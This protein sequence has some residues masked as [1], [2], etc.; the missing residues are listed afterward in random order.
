[1]QSSNNSGATVLF[2]G[3]FDPLH[4]GHRDAFAQAKALGSELIVVVAR[5]STIVRDKHRQP[6]LPEE[7]RRLAVAADP[8]VDSA[9]LGDVD[10]NS[11]AT[12]HSVPFDILALGYDQEPS[13]EEVRNILHA[14]NLRRV[15]VVRLAPHKPDSYKSSLLRKG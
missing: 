10:A 1:M 8:S 13:D 5:D 6:S 9:L 4:D 11:Y 7:D 3:S 15:R 12:L 2:F 14:N